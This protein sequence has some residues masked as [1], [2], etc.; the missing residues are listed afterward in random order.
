MCVQDNNYDQY[1]KRFI[2]V[3]FFTVIAFIGIILWGNTQ[4]RRSRKD[5]AKALDTHIVHTKGLLEASQ[6]MYYDHQKCVTEELNNLIDSLSRQPVKNQKMIT[7]ALKSCL[8]EI[9]NLEGALDNSEMRHEFEMMKNDIGVTLEYLNS[10][11]QLHIDKMNNTVS[12]FELWAAILTIIFL[13]FSFYSLYK[14]DELVKQGREGVDYINSLKDKGEK[15]FEKFNARSNKALESMKKDVMNSLEKER[16][17]LIQKYNLLTESLQDQ[18][19]RS[20]ESVRAALDDFSQ[21]KVQV[22]T[23][24]DKLIEKMGEI[25]EKA[26][27]VLTNIEKVAYSVSNKSNDVVNG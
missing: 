14:V 24:K 10:H 4:F 25:D 16:S 21:Y 5:L 1:L 12:T 7:S 8:V 6:S 15:S 9:K 13:V 11:V 18:I 23:E 22:E 17:L 2:K 19:V 20:Q 3:L 26:K 27:T